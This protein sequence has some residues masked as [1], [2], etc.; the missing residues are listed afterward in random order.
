MGEL[1]IGGLPAEV[2]RAL[3]HQADS[4]HRSIED[5]A[6]VILIQALLPGV[7]LGSMLADSGRGVELTEEESAGFDRDPSPPREIDL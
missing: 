7:R 5:E 4:N 6:R 1:E 3:E 2:L